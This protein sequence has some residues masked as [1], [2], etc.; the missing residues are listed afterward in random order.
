MKNL[1]VKVLECLKELN[2]KYLPPNLA[3]LNSNTTGF[4]IKPY[5]EGDK[6]IKSL[7]MDEYPK[8]HNGFS[9]NFDDKKIIFYNNLLPTTI[10]NFV[11]AHEIGHIWLEH[12]IKNSVYGKSEDCDEEAAQEREADEFAE[13]LLSQ[14]SFT[15]CADTKTSKKVSEHVQ[16]YIND[17]EA[18]K[19][20]FIKKHSKLIC[21][22]A[23]A[24]VAA[25]TIFYA[26]IN[27]NRQS[28]PSAAQNNIYAHL[29]S[30]PDNSI[31]KPVS[32]SVID[33]PDA[34]LTVYKTKSGDK[35]HLSDCQYVKNKSNT[36]SL[37]YQEALNAGLEPCKVCT[38]DKWFS[39]SN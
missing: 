12:T 5:S 11:I 36:I 23:A 35:F 1:E 38:P 13:A 20:S 27:H 39:L 21:I 7:G 15:Q 31:N 6:F 3:H 28:L 16:D 2:I 29:Q 32:S 26:S 4:K 18:N 19:N 25:I 9:I 17:Y 34:S 30:T 24:A 37:D 8:Q 10:T 22:S 14:L 33:K